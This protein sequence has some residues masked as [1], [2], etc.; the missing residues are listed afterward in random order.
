VHVHIYE[1]IQHTPTCRTHDKNGRMRMHRS[2]GRLI[3][4]KGEVDAAK[5]DTEVIELHDVLTV[6]DTAAIRR[7]E[8]MI[9]Y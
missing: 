8:Q 4:E 7:G 3:A 2:K 5:R 6:R 1:Y 9:V